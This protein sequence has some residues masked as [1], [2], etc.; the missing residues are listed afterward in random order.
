MNS[1]EK[2]K[3]ILGFVQNV[4]ETDWGFMMCLKQELEHLVIIAQAEGIK[5]A[6]DMILGEIE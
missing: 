4:T 1:K 5:E 6:K 3:D 2:I